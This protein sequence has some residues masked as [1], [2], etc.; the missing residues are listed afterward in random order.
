MSDDRYD[1][2]AH[3][4]QRTPERTALLF[5]SER[6]T[7]A[8]LHAASNGL[9]LVL[10]EA[11]LAAGDRVALFAGNRPATVI[12]LHAVPRLHATLVPLNL[13]LS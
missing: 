3:R 2:L 13:R 11:G 12:A 7:V 4:A 10:R 8:A 1:W 6:W 9:A 5:E